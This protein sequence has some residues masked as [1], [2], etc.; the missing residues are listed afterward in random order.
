MPVPFGFSVG[1]FISAI[2]L[3]HDVI[4][5]LKDSSGSSADFQELIRELY[6]LER[7]LLAVR[8]LKVQPAQEL[9]LDAIKQAATQCQIIVDTFL[10]KNRKFQ[11]TLGAAE[12]QHKWKGILHKIIW[13]VYRK[14][15][16]DQ[17][18]AARNGHT[19]SINMLLL[20]VQ[21]CVLQVT[22]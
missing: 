19:S 13:R 18:R 14:E 6:S 3:I 22:R 20:T 17:F 11:P 10:Q 7:A 9:Q 2:E 12:S 21:L 1:D 16:V 4:D 15:D 5:A 8:A